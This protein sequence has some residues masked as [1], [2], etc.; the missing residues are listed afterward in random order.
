MNARKWT[1]GQPY[2]S[3][4]SFVAHFEEGRGAFFNHKYLPYGWIQNWSLHL[5]SSAIAGRRLFEAN[6]TEEP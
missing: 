3:L 2:R 4:V 6:P 1:K 5:I